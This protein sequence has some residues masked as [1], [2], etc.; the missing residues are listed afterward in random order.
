MSLFDYRNF[1]FPFGGGN[2][3]GTRPPL[4]AKI[5]QWLLGTSD[6]ENIDDK[7][8]IVNPE[9]LVQGVNCLES[10]GAQSLS[11]PTIANGAVVVNAGTAV[12]TATVG[13]IIFTAGTISQIQLDGVMTYVCEEGDFFP[14]D[15]SGRGNDIV[16]MTCTWGTSD[17]LASWCCVKGF[18]HPD[19]AYDISFLPAVADLSFSVALQST[20]FSD[21]W[22]GDD[23]NK[24]YLLSFNSRYV[25]QYTLT[26]PHDPETLVYDSKFLDTTPQVGDNPRGILFNTAGT[27]F[28]VCS[29]YWRYTYQYN[30]STPWDLS[31]AVWDSKFYHYNEDA[32]LMSIAMSP[33]ETKF[34][35]YGTN[36][37]GFY[38][39]D[40]PDPG[41]VSTMVYTGNWYNQPD[42]E[43][44]G[45]RSLV[46]SPDGT[47]AFS[48][49]SNLKIN[50]YTFSTPWDSTT[51]VWN[52]EMD[53]SSVSTFRWNDDGTVAWVISASTDLM[54]KY[55]MDLD[56]PALQ[57]PAME[58]SSSVATFDG[59]GDQVATPSV[60]VPLTF[61]FISN[62]TPTTE[63]D[64][65]YFAVGMATMLRQYSDGHVEA[66]YNNAA[67]SSATGVLTVG[68]MTKVEYRVTAGLLQV[69][70]DDVE[71]I[72]TA[73]TNVEL[74][75]A[76][77][78]GNRPGASYFNG[79]MRDAL[80]T[81]IFSYDFTD[82]IGKSTD[83]T[84]TDLYGNG[85]DGT[86][87]SADIDAFW[88]R[89]ELRT[90]G[91]VVDAANYLLITH[92][93][94]KHNNGFGGNIIEAP[95]ALNVIDQ[96][97]VSG[98]T[99]ADE[100]SNGV[101]TYDGIVNTR[102]KFSGGIGYIAW[103]GGN[104][105]LVT[106]F[107][108]DAHPNT[109]GTFP[110]KTGWNIGVGGTAPVLEYD[111]YMLEGVEL[112]S[113]TITE[114]LAR[115]NTTQ[116]VVDQ[117][118][119][120]NGACVLRERLV[121]SQSTEMTGAWIQDAE[122]WAT[123]YTDECGTFIDALRDVNGVLILDVNGDLIGVQP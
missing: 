50:Q 35:L 71:V 46:F 84:V 114:D 36:N 43:G 67:F 26:T 14:L 19:M 9:P 40:M 23:G 91:D 60:T 53:M 64:V 21:F 56:A 41:E 78:V 31:T 66:R 3:G 68:S 6:G 76:V 111:S 116:R 63:N 51:C 86:I 37:D 101:Y 115:T 80:M 62:L 8:D 10:T 42:E 17:S 96:I 13:I 61:S 100:V 1:L 58:P 4:I 73:I 104:W 103:D 119:K 113:H 7:L 34:Y 108:S 83:T 121:Y 82:K 72:N 11:S 48:A 117:W 33:D 44:N 112:K 95:T 102:P 97:T 30:L 15:V 18:S 109:G 2:L 94:G 90:E 122:K 92:P 98:L 93:G 65:A 70:L 75:S 120:P 27:R 89:R 28:Y 77:N 59:V 39:Y 52:G 22:I 81:G 99:G 12:G 29:D 106:G 74:V 45:G 32:T 105:T 87:T 118:E 55:A 54:Y 110:N 107:Y 20:F 88:A 57:I 24:M 47:K 69:L 5:L 85:N 16:S 123:K 49:D 79:L 25:Y 38:E